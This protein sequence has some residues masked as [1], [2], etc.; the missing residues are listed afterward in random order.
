MADFIKKLFGLQSED[1]QA[2]SQSEGRA[3]AMRFLDLPGLSRFLDKLMQ[4]AENRFRKNTDRVDAEDVLYNG[5]ALTTAIAND[6]FRGPKGDKG[7]TGA[8][9]PKGAAATF[10]IID[11]HLFAVYEE[12]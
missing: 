1:T 2:A 11:G 3:S 10:E 6:E 7:D 8:Q 12:E 5:E 4:W 9:G